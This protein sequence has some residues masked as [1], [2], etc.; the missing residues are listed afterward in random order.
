[1][2]VVKTTYLRDDRDITVRTLLLVYDSENTRYKEC[3][4]S[5]KLMP[6]YAL[7]AKGPIVDQVVIHMRDKGV[8]ASEWTLTPP[9][10]AHID[11]LEEI[12]GDAPIK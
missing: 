3:G 11:K 12:L 8:P 5:H 6:N 7:Q 10:F 2:H 4:A 1:M 9:Q